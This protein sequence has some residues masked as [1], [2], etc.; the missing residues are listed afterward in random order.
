MNTVHSYNVNKQFAF[1]AL[2]CALFIHISI[3]PL[4]KLIKI[5]NQNEIEPKVILDLINELE[6]KLPKPKINPININENI[7]INKPEPIK[8]HIKSEKTNQIIKNN[9]DITEENLNIKIPK[10]E[11]IIEKINQPEI[12]ENIKDIPIFTKKFNSEIKIMKNETVKVIKPNTISNVNIENIDNKTNYNS[13]PSKIINST[14]KLKK[15]I[16]KN[17]TNENIPDLTQ[18]QL[19]AL[20]KYKNNLR[21]VIQSFASENYPKK[22][23]RRRIEGKVQ[24]IFKLNT[25]GTI[26][27]IK[28]GP[29]TEAPQE[30]IEAAMKAIRESSPFETD[31]LLKK[32]NEFSIEIIY[33]IQ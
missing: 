3:I 1:I 11:N 16:I 10:P 4:S 24:L 7:K 29:K 13:V 6:T 2:V 23:Q 8:P 25:N 27:N 14:N 20:E 9:I 19:N 32:K 18:D 22:L 5:D 30:L 12:I 15:P 21:A 33:K 26:L 17:N 31:E 28:H